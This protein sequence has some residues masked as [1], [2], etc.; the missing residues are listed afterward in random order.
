[1]KILITGASGYIGGQLLMSLYKEHE[2]TC[3]LR[4]KRDYLESQYSNV[5]FT[6]GD[7]A[8]S[9]DVV[10][11]C[12]GID[13]IFYLIHAMGSDGDFEKEDK[14]NAL[15]FSKAANKCGVKRIIYLGGLVEADSKMS[16]HMKSRAEVGRLLKS[17]GVQVFEFRAS[18]VLGAGSLSF[19]MIRALVEHLPIM[20]CPAWVRKHCQAIYIGDLIKYLKSAVDLNLSG[21]HIFEIGG[22]DIT[23]YGDLMKSYAK[24][25]SL[26][27]YM[28]PVPI[29]TPRLS[30]LWLGLVTP[31]YSRVGRKIID[32]VKHDSM[33]AEPVSKDLFPFNCIGVDEA[34]SLIQK[35]EDE[36]YVH[37]RWNDAMAAAG[38]KKIDWKGVHFGNRLV[39][40]RTLKVN[41]SAK[42]AF[43]PIQTI[44]GDSGW[45]CGNWL[46]SLRGFIDLLFGGPG[47]RRGRR[48][49]QKLHE[50]DVLDFWRVDLYKENEVLL[51]EAE[52]KL[53]GRAWLK[54]EVNP[55]DENSCEIRQTA[56]FDPLGFFGVLY[57][58]VVVPLHAYVFGGMIKEIKKR[59][60]VNAREN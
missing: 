40:S 8:N 34:L 47:V 14:I 55:I 6:Y 36:G 44:G 27:R 2:I 25:R 56:I 18:V 48:D 26:K 59:A 33:V 54:F 7:A 29:L 57:W 43:Y 24:L 3:L 52:M 23:T 58:H 41:C 1:M 19:E 5:N 60:L 51:L 16:K 46:W 10:R 38:I 50:G 12:E 32:S 13:V 15:N 31:L 11:A 53:P 22:R 21:S 28:I 4:S 9:E 45:Y 20:V 39:D 35:N 17:D 42:Q 49:P 30:S 37:T